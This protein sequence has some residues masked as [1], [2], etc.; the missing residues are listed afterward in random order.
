MVSVKVD[1]A[2]DPPLGEA[3]RLFELGGELDLSDARRFDVSADGRR[4]LFARPTGR[5]GGAPQR[6]VLVQN[7]REEFKNAAA[8]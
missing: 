6:M 3:T 4:F 8:R 1:P 5:H 7:W 2:Q